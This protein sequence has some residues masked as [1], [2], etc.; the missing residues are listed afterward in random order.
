MP[1][2][3]VPPPGAADEHIRDGLMAMKVSIG[4]I[5]GPEDQDVIEQTA[6]TVRS[7]L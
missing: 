1:T 3:S 2:S 4:H 6:I 5:A 7:G